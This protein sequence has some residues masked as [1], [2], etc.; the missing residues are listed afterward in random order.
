M[1]E[2]PYFLIIQRSPKFKM[3]RNVEKSRQITW[4]LDIITHQGCIKEGE[5][6]RKSDKGRYKLD[7]E[8]IQYDCRELIKSKLLNCKQKHFFKNRMDF[9]HCKYLL[10]C[11]SVTFN[12]PVLYSSRLHA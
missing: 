9:T 3:L 5:E 6:G 4:H 10:S 8:S 12:C 11:T 1:L 2:G 7:P